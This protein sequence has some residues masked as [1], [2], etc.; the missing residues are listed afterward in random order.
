MISDVGWCKVDEE[1][2]GVNWNH[3]EWS[4]T[5]PITRKREKALKEN[6]VSSLIVPQWDITTRIESKDST[7]I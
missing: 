1:R 3:S 2:R 6:S 5:T 4:H 7:Q